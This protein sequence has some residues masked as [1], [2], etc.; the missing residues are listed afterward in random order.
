MRRLYRA[1]LLPRLI[2]EK[3]LLHAGRSATHKAIFH[4]IVDVMMVLRIDTRTCTL[5]QPLD[6]LSLTL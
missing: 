3:A 6:Y 5:K 1:L 4:G 2:E